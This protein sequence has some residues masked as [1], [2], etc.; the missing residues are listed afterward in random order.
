[1]HVVLLL[2]FPVTLQ[3]C[4]LRFQKVV[5]LPPFKRGCHVITRPLLQRLPELADFEVGLA[6][7]FGM[8][9]RFAHPALCYYRT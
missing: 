2:V 5:E 4:M 3:L 7:F 1:M 6:N 9:P 8:G